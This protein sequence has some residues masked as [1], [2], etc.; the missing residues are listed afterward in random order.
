MT[1]QNVI[2]DIRDQC[3]DAT[4]TYRWSDAK[5]LRWINAGLLRL[6]A[7]R[8][9][10]VC[11]EDD[12]VVVIEPPPPVSEVTDPLPIED[13]WAP[14]LVYYGLHRLYASDTDELAPGAVG[15]AAAFEALFLREAQ[16]M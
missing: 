5:L 11:G 6:F 4:A 15:R 10:C 7:M 3:S 12:T 16:T 9:D 2:D 14:A 13:K 8:P 1:V